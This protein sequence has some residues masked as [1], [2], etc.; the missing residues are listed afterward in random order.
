MPGRL[1]VVYVL[2]A[3]RSLVNAMLIVRLA[4]AEGGVLKLQLTLATVEFGGSLFVIIALAQ[5]KYL[6]IQVFRPFVIISGCL[7]VAGQALA[8]IYN[9]R[10]GVAAPYAPMFGGLLFLA[11]LGWFQ[12]YVA[13]PKVRAYLAPRLAPPGAPL[14]P[15]IAEEPNKAL[16]PTPMS[17]TSPAAQEPRQ[18]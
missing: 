13:S 5:R 12:A 2:M 9:D 16:E 3:I 11:F 18:P 4:G 7:T 14:L 1:I 17:V 8:G 15:A 10:A 6:A